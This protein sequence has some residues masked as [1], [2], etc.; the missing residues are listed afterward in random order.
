M[1]YRPV[2]LLPSNLAAVPEAIQLDI[3]LLLR[4]SFAN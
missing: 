1:Q 4:Y 2:V 3:P